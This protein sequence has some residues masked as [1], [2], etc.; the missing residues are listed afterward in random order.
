[1]KI[2]SILSVAVITM[3]SISSAIADP[4]N[5]KIAVLFDSRML[6]HDTGINHPEKPERLTTASTAIRNAKGLIKHLVWPTIKEASDETLQLVH[7]EDY[8]RLVA[9]EVEAQ[10]KDQTAYL[11][12]GDVVISKD[13][14]MASRVAVGA[15]IEGV[16]QIMFNNN[17][18]TALALVR[19]PGH[20]ASADRG[21]GFC[22]YNNVAIAA[23]YAQQ[24][25]G[26]QRILIVDFD[27][28]HGNGTQDIFYDDNSVFYFSVHQHPLYP[29]TGSPQETG[30]GKGKGFTLNVELPKGSGDAELINALNS[31]LVKAMDEF[32][33][34]FILV[35]AG[36][37]G[38]Q[39][40]PLGGLHYTEKGYQEVA[41]VLSDLAKKHADA[42]TLYV[43][44]GGYSHDNTSQSILA[45]LHALAK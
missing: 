20:H 21:M 12:T 13:S 4:K 7:T 24:R 32:R 44:E 22:I 26:L 25:Y 29:G 1:M 2:L 42:K 38:H 9:S 8:L 14:D 40:D 45:I 10:E 15:V 41:K 35:S 19:P 36:F 37:D 11:S 23:R 43:M 28:H 5:K 3:V 18:F 31:K 17:T 27:V 34:E 16:D 33:P 30:S 6:A 39:A